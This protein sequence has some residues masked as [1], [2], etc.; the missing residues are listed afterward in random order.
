MMKN[1]VLLIVTLLM[2]VSCST[3]MKKKLLNEKVFVVSSLMIN[4]E[5]TLWNLKGT[6]LIRF[7]PENKCELPDLEKGGKSNWKL[8]DVG[9]K[10]FVIE[11]Y[12]S[13]DPQ[14]NDVFK[15]KLEKLDAISFILTLQ[16]TTRDI[17]IIAGT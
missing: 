14:W 9:Y 1:R 11:F 2:I 6:N 16:S 7:L 10:T 13:K 12:N 8:T 15:G 3:N 5:E 17:V 4:G